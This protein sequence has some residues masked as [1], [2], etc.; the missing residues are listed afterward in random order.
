MQIEM[1]RIDEIHRYKN[2]PRNNKTAIQGV[3][4]S[5]KEFGFKV[6]IIIDKS[7]EIIAGDTRYQAAKQLNLTEIP[8]ICADDLTDEQVK[9]FRLADNKVAEASDWNFELL[10]SEISEILNIDMELFGFEIND[11][12]VGELVEED[13]FEI[14]PPAEAKAK[15]GEIYKLGNHRVMCGDSTDIESVERLM[16]GYK[17][18][19]LITDPPY[20][21]DYT[22]KTKEALKIENDKMENDDFR[23]FLMDAFKA[24]D[25][26]M[27][28]GAVFYIWHA[29]SEVYSFGAACFEVGWKIRQC[30]IWNKNSMV[31]GRQD[32]QWK[33][34]PC[35]YGWKEGASHYW[36]GDRKQTTVLE[37]NKPTRNGT[38]PT[39]KPVELFDYQI[40]N[41]TRKGE[42]VLDLF[43][44]SGTTIVACEQNGRNAFCMEYDPRYVDVII[45]RWEKLTGKKAVFIEE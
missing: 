42:N 43:T 6:P 4:N 18:D 27:K 24:A 20:N 33:H 11:E 19:L 37:F 29:N 38:H 2:N 39:M 10:D 15:R 12:V 31:I 41:S 21:I 30:L 40:K 1:K 44:G 16:G 13:E 5:I 45:E 22:G 17:A 35:L 32:Y 9:A 14:E 26:V 28:K 7:G 25:S 8:C 23:K 3:L 36:A 34:E